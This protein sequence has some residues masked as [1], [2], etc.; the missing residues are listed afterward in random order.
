[1]LLFASIV[2]RCLAI[3]WCLVLVRRL[4]N[5]RNDWVILTILMTCMSSLAYGVSRQVPRWMTFPDSPGWRVEELPG[6]IVSI[7][8]L[9]GTLALHRLIVQSERIETALR[10]SEHKWRSI[11]ENSPDVISILDEQG[12]R[13]FG[14]RPLELHGAQETRKLA[15]V[16][17]RVRETS[18]AVEYETTAGNGSAHRCYSHRVGAMRGDKQ[19]ESFVLI[20]TDITDRKLAEE[21]L[22]RARDELEKRV[23]ERTEELLAANRQLEREMAE[24]RRADIELRHSEARLQSILDNTTAV[25]YVKDRDGRYLLINKQFEQL[26]GVSRNDFV[27]KTDFDLFDAEIAASFRENDLRVVESGR[28]WEFDESVPHDGGLRTYLSVKFPLRDV[29]DQITAT[30]G[31]STDITDRKRAEMELRSERRLLEQLLQAHERDRKLTAYEIHDGIVPYITGALMFLEAYRGNRNDQPTTANNEF[32]QALQLLR[33]TVDEARR[34]ISGLRPP[35]IDELGI[36]AAIEYLINEHVA[37]GGPPVEF[38]NRSSLDRLEPLLEGALYRIAQE[39]LTNVRRH[40]Q[41]DTA[42]L[43][44]DANDGHVELTV[45]DFGVGFQSSQVSENRFGLQ[46]IRERANLLRGWAHIDS[47]PGR[48]TRVTVQIPLN[49]GQRPRMAEV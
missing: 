42:R 24:R 20:S 34:M 13:T 12:Q 2:L 44:L 23:A 33:R 48:G 9:V 30:C 25:V 26:F 35:I 14:N 16:L 6:F 40:S 27:G 21:E 10:E 39:A 3:I 1:M 31:I 22:K 8:L 43:T 49:A 5:W 11:V 19:P 29:D 45:E 37:Q 28:S 17:Q 18:S 47:A 15:D 41:S 32:Q 36:A 7:V 4:W 38:Q 46:G